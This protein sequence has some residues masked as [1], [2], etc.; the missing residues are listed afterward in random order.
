MWTEGQGQTALVVVGTNNESIQPDSEVVVVVVSVVTGLRRD[1]IRAT[2]LLLPV[3]GRPHPGLGQLAENIEFRNNL[4][5]FALLDEI[6]RDL[7]YK[8]QT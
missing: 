2:S 5:F 4:R 6:N 8:K 7:C 3:C 1:G